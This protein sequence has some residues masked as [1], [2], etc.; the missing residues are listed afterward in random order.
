MK[1]VN[2]DPTFPDGPVACRLEASLGVRDAWRFVVR[3]WCWCA[4]YRPDGVLGPLTPEQLAREA[5]YQG[6]PA[7]F[8]EVLTDPENEVLRLEE[9]T[10][11][12]VALG[13]ARVLSKQTAR[14]DRRGGF[15]AWR[16]DHEAG[17][18]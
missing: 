4:R 8:F 2:V 13:W 10:G 17:G 16:P 7:T 3:L 14:R 12:L 18:L 15:V 6:D 5:G 9:E 11:S 1:F